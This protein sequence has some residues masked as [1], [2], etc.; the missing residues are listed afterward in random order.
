M[1][2]NHYDNSG[3][4]P[5]ELS[6]GKPVLCIDDDPVSL[7][8]L[9]STLSKAGYTAITAATGME[10][11]EVLITQS[12]CL[13]LLD[14]QMPD[15]NGLGFISRLRASGDTKDIPVIIQSGAASKTNLSI[16]VSHGISGVLIK[17]FSADALLEKVTKVLSG[18]AQDFYAKETDLLIENNSTEAP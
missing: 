3:K 7:I 1:T 2:T 15:M 13:I 9:T 11:Q 10:A 8:F 6:N 14:L 5:Q 12:P 4:S 18:S 16:C 17:P